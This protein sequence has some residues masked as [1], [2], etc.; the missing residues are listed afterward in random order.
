MLWTF[1]RGAH[2]LN[3]AADSITIDVPAG[4][5]LVL[6]ELEAIGLESA[7]AAANQL[8]IYDVTTLGSG[9]T[10]T[11]LTISAWGANP[12]G[13]AVPTGLTARHGYATQPVLGTLRH[14][15]EWQPLGGSKKT[16]LIEPL[17]FW[18]AAAYQVSIRPIAGT[19][20]AQIKALVELK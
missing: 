5:I 16:P 4:R 14:T 1:R 19:Q 7:T 11:S 3:T 17:E 18:K 8:G 2:A 15:L 10:P 9:G 20:Q 12:D 13:Y 6:H